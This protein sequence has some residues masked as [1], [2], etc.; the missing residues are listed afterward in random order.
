[1]SYPRDTIYSR[2][3]ELNAVSAAHTVYT[4]DAASAVVCVHSVNAANGITLVA[5]GQISDDGPWLLMHLM[6]TND[7]T[8]TLPIAVTPAISTLPTH[9]WRVDLQGLV[10]LRVRV[11]AR[12]GGGV[13]VA[14]KL[15][16]VAY[17]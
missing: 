15:C 16:P 4:A 6:P 10:N 9:G 13:V 12:T 17:A 2:S 1:M 8:P 11:S 7:V 5:E 14:T 3:A